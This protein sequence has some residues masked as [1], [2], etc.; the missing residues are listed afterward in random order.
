MY[1]DS[2]IH[3]H[4]EAARLNDVKRTDCVDTDEVGYF[5]PVV[6]HLYLL[7]ASDNLFH[8]LTVNC[9]AL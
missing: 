5:M 7:V 9:T 6:I 4:A 3:Q 1:V 8:L 2:L